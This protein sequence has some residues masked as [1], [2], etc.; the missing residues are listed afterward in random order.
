VPPAGQVV[1]LGAHAE[2]IVADPVTHIVAVGVR[3]PAGLALLDG[4]T[5]VITTR[6]S[7]PGH[8]RH[9]QLAASGGPVLVPA[10]RSGALLT[11]ALPAGTVTSQVQV[12]RYAH[13]A[14]ATTSGTI[15]VAD[16]LGN[17][18]VL[19]RDGR[20]VHRFT[21][22][23]Q[24]GGLAAADDLV[25]MV[26]VAEHTLT[27]YDTTR[28]ARR[29]QVP[30]GDGPTHI[31]ADRR[32]RLV[33]VDTAG[34]RLLT[35]TTTPALRRVGSTPL[36]G[37]PYG[38]AYDPNRD[39]FWIT[40]TARN[41]VVGLDLSGTQPREV[42]RFPTVRQPN[43]VTIDPDTGRVFVASRTDGTLQLIDPPV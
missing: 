36:P 11:V 16:E 31:V 34:N 14:T 24:P 1:A 8:L 9:L 17:A 27:V 28:P 43:T 6:V 19:V 23:A 3:D 25:G 7:L 40:L 4:R 18:V 13:D 37:T 33:V 26:D 42:T 39:R 10:E 35:F 41:Q 2:G 21:G 12:G 30:A 38:I 32:G 22:M 29:A 5:G 15:A 20:V